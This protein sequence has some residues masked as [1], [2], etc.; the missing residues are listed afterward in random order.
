V[1]SHLSVT[2][3]SRRP[4][5][6]AFALILITTVLLGFRLGAGPFE[7]SS[8]R[9]CHEV[10]REMVESGDYLVPRFDGA[11]PAPEA[12]ALL[13]ARRGDR[14]RGGRGLPSLD[15][16][17]IGDRRTAPPA[18]RDG[19]RGDDRIRERLPA[20]GRVL[21]LVVPVRP[22]PVGAAM[23]RCGSPSPVRAR[24][25]RSIATPRRAPS[26]GYP[27]SRSRYSSHSSPRPPRPSLRS[28]C[29]FF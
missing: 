19:L 23:R 3:S 28:C 22:L 15:A 4:M 26:S 21:T 20:L 17:A 12:T 2:T 7:R 8:E 6:A 25:F 16:P 1:I 29:R 9:R 13:L 18:C 11:I 14:E 5:L 24:S 10:A 27:H